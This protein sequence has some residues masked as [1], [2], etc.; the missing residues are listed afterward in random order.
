MDMKL[1]TDGGFILAGFTNNIGAG[2]NDMYLVKVDSDGNETW[3]STYG[4]A[5][6]EKANGVIQTS[7]G[8]YMIV[9][10]SLTF[11]NGDYDLYLVKTSSIGVQE[12]SGNYGSTIDD[13]GYDVVEASNGDV[14]AIGTLYQP[15]TWWSDCLLVI[16][17]YNVVSVK[18]FAFN[19]IEPNVFPN[20]FKE[21][22]TISF[23]LDEVNY[24]NVSVKV[25]DLLGKEMKSN[26]MLAK[27]SKIVITREG[28]NTGM[29]LYII[30]VDGR[31]ISTGKINVI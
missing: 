24:S 13:Q 28:L 22:T 4:G 20:P 1:T 16:P 12:W 8:G 29:Y 19:K 23:Q 14:Y 15:S 17:D 27:D 25:Y 11:T 30:E 18:E 6:Y 10:T 31:H 9:G 21:Q 26:S 2:D 7:D 5:D 3:S